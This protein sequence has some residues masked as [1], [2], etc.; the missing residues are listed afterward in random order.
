MGCTCVMPT[1][2]TAVSHLCDHA[3]CCRL[4]DVMGYGLSCIA[5]TKCGAAL[6]MCVI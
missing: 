3:A 2:L 4:L 6:T 5:F 1:A